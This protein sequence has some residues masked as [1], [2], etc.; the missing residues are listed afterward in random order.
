MPSVDTNGIL[1][2]H[3]DATVTYPS[4]GGATATKTFSND[5]AVTVDVVNDA[6]FSLTGLDGNHNAVEGQ[7]VNAVVTDTDAPASGITY[8][9]QAFDGTTWNNVQSG[10]G[11]SYTPTEAVEGEQLRVN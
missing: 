10:T 7:Q 5:L 6:T 8:T 4:P 2:L 11:A 3:Y 9:F 1:T